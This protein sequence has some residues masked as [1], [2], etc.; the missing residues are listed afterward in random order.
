MAKQKLS[1]LTDDE[2]KALSAVELQQYN[3]DMPET[4]YSNPHIHRDYPKMLYKSEG[5]FVKSTTVRSEKERKALGAGWEESP[6][7]F[8][9]ETAPAAPAV[10]MT[11]FSVPIPNDATAG[12]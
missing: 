2:Y 3:M 4:D 6:A 8:G 7:A 12:A 11:S 10:A 5:G 1:K 9:V